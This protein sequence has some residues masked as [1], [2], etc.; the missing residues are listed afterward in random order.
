MTSFAKKRQELVDHHLWLLEQDNPV[1]SYDSWL[2]LSQIHEFHESEF[3]GGYWGRLH[4][5]VWPEIKRIVSGSRLIAPYVRNF[6]LASPD[7]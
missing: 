5:D 3:D 7:E 4:P 2:D 6:I 1:L